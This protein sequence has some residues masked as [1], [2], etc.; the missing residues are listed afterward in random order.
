MKSDT[1][2][3]KVG[4]KKYIGVYFNTETD[5]W[6]A[7]VQLEGGSVSHVGK[8]TDEEEAAEAYDAAAEDLLDNPDLNFP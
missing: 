5:L 3:T 2:T 1:D 6:E 4:S 7:E 8:F